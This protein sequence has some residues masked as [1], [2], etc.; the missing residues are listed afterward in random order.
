MLFPKHVETPKNTGML[1]PSTGAVYLRFQLVKH[2][3]RWPTCVDFHPN[4]RLFHPAT[5]RC[6][7]QLGIGPAVTTRLEV[8]IRAGYEAKLRAARSPDDIYIYNIYIYIYIHL[9]IHLLYI[10]L[11]SFRYSLPS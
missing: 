1:K 7:R 2:G 4:P 5:P 9:S 8:P 10:H 6:A 3:F 11:E